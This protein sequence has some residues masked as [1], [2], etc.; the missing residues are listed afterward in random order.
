MSNSP[1]SY[2]PA[3]LA[4]M[5]TDFV[6]WEKRRQGEAGF[7]VRLLRRHGCRKLLDASLGD[8]CDS[9][10]LLQLGFDV[11]SNEIDSLYLQKGLLNAQ[12]NGVRL[13]VSSVDWREFGQKMPA[14][15]F[16]AVFLLGNSL[17]LLFS[18]AD[19]LASLKGF[20]HVLRPGGLLLVDQRNYQNMLDNPVDS[21]RSF[22]YSKRYVYCGDDVEAVPVRV[23]SKKVTFRYRHVNGLEA[24]LDLYPFRKGELPALMTEAGFQG[25]DEYSDFKQGYDYGS[26]FHQYV[27]FKSLKK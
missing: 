23:L 7:L 1:T 26:D 18:K 10:Y 13:D 25:T 16:D 6:D 3:A 14:D 5:W 2:N 11:S 12:R 21:V 24:L 27:G 8:G 20:L 17:T 22:R 4:E 9:I 19:R 15:A